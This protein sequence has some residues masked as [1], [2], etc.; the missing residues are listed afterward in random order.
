MSDFKPISFR[1][2]S[3][4]RDTGKVVRK[5]A[6]KGDRPTDELPEELIDRRVFA[7]PPRPR[8]NVVPDL[9]QLQ[10]LIAQALKALKNGVYWDRG[11]IV[12]IL[13]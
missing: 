7:P 1:D 13:L 3:K 11:S 2:V 5:P 9:P 10:Q 4:L 6:L 12:N 8:V